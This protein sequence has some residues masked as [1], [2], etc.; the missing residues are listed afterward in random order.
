MNFPV[1]EEEYLKQNFIED[2]EI[3][4]KLHTKFHVIKDDLIEKNILTSDHVCFVTI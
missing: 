4:L 2:D 3:F 1:F